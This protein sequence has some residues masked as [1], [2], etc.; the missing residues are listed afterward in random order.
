MMSLFLAIYAR[1]ENYVNRP[2]NIMIAWMREVRRSAAGGAVRPPCALPAGVY[3][4][5]YCV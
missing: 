1:K 5:V 4:Y 2:L 3:M